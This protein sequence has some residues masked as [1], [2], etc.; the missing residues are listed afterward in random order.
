MVETLSLQL[1]L[2][3]QLNHV[4]QAMAT[5]SVVN[6]QLRW[7]RNPKVIRYV[8]DFNPDLALSDRQWL[9][10][11]ALV[12]WEQHWGG[13]QVSWLQVLGG[14]CLRQ[15]LPS[16]QILL[17]PS[18]LALGAW[19]WQLAITD[20]DFQACPQTDLPVRLAPLD[21]TLA[22]RLQLSPK[23]VVQY[24]YGR[25]R[26]LLAGLELNLEPKVG[27]D[28]L[29]PVGLSHHLLPINNGESVLRCLVQMVDCLTLCPRSQGDQPEPYGFAAAYSLS[30]AVDEW[31]GEREM[32]TATPSTMVLLKGID[33]VLGAV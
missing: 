23:A 25:C 8:C 18:P 24:T 5:P 33:R 19:L 15:I 7:G 3:Q 6:Y 13:P 11:M 12:G 1:I 10:R 29:S 16:G 27:G 31:L 28:Q 26:Q 9:A 22:Q 2:A 32:L 30:V 17:T 21:P 20:Q 14:H 4:L